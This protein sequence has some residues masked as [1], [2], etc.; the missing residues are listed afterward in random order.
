MLILYNIDSN[1]FDKDYF[2][3]G[4]L[5]NKSFY[6]NYH[7][8]PQR[9]FKEALAIIDCLHLN[10]N[11]YVL[12]I[13][14]AK[15]FLIR[16]LRE[17]EI[18]ADGSDISKYALSFAPEGCWDCSDD[19]SWDKHS[20]FGYTNI[21]VKDMLEHLNKQQL[22]ISLNNFSKVA[23]EMLCIVPIG[24]DGKYRIPE[25]ECDQSHII[26][27]NESWW[28]C[29]FEMNGWNVIDH[30]AHLN[31]IKDNWIHYPD[32]NHVFVLEYN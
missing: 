21:V 18:K 27:E 7:W 8:M 25:Y 28:Y 14:C 23:K 12:E 29:F 9:S 13:G 17:L 16:A 4:K 19:S 30:F 5:T 20:N 3:N 32:G 11:S 24:S 15:G 31:G 1:F 22:E 2:E 6:E 26:R 10:K